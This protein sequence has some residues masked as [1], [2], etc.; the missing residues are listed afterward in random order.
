M[1]SLTR[2]KEYKIEIEICSEA[3]FNS[4]EKEGNLVQ[5]RAQTDKHGFIYFHAK[6]LKGQLKRQAMWLLKQYINIDSKLADEFYRSIVNLFG[7]NNEEVS[8]IYENYNI[9]YR[10]DYPSV[11]IIKLSNLELDKRIRQYFVDYQSEDKDQMYYRISPHDLIEAQTHIRTG[12]QLEYDIAKNRMINSFHTVKK[13]LFFY[14]TVSFEETNM[15]TD[16]L[17][18][19]F[20][21]IV[22]SFKRIGAGIHRGRGEIKSKLLVRENEEAWDEFIG[23]GDE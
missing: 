15:L 4:G 7:I 8:N 14:T 5:S 12:I 11:G 23:R 13:G 10:G 2:D 9:L 20:A 21:R 1:N 19:D 18:Q 17:L 22:Y 16:S 6:T 3:I